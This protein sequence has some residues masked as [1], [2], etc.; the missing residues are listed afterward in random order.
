MTYSKQIADALRSIA[1]SGK[2]FAAEI[3][4]IDKIAEAWER[5][6]ARRISAAGLDLIK[7]FEGLRLT[8]YKCPADVPTI[9]Y[10][11]TGPHVRM[12]MTITEAEAE[13]LLIKD[14]ARFEAIVSEIGGK[15][16]QGQFDALTSL[17]FNVGGTNVARSTLL[18]LHKAGDYAGAAREFPRWNRAAGRVLAGLTRRREAEAKLYRGEA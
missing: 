10:G 11:S 18:K 3:P 14:L 16:T 5:R 6:A 1:P 13:D 17:A 4:L 12:G 2:L 15:M 9:G 8:A 7:G